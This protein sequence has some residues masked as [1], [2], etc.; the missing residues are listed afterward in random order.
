MGLQDEYVL[1]F[2]NSK[3]SRQQQPFFGIQY[4]ISTHYPYD[5]P[6]SFAA[7]LPK[8]YTAPMKSMRYY[9]YSL[10][11]FFNAA[12]KE[13]WFNNTVFIFCSDHW[14]FP[15]GVKGT[16]NA[17]TGYKIP[18]IIFDAAKKEKQLINTPVSQFDII[19]TILSIAGYRDS[20][21]SYGGNLLDSNSL[22]PY[23]F[24][25]PNSNICQVTDSNFVLDYNIVLNK[26]EYFYNYKTD[27]N[28]A[29]NLLSEDI[30]NKDRIRLTKLAEAFIQ[31]TGKHFNNT[32]SKQ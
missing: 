21:I 25:K 7:T 14:M 13:V 8:N 4:N 3:L 23:V 26:P 17:V 31:Q 2:F 27:K 9:D 11:K 30:Y 5:I 28:S 6:D 22:R 18:I 32:S 12:K 20:I 29:K 19:G 10:Q 15:E 24:S 16:Y 1:D